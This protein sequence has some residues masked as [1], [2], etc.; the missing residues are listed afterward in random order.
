M[1]EENY[2][3]IIV[4]A[5]TVG[6]ILIRGSFISL[7]GKI[8]ISSDLKELFS[9]IPAAIFP[10]LIVP[11]TFFH[12]GHVEWLYGKERFMVLLAAALAGYFYRNT[13]FV[14]TF[15]LVLLYLVSNG[16]V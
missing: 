12:A 15:G 5:L 14:I 8:S 6:T 4:S 2:F 16:K 1:I 13:L 9:Y 3:I 11:A 10:A 7:S